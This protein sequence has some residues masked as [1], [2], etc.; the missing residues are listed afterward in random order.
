[1]S[2]SASR[3]NA[4]PCAAVSAKLHSPRQG[5]FGFGDETAH[6]I[7]ATGRISLIAPAVC[8]AVSRVCAGVVFL[9]AAFA[10]ALNRS[11]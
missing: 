5:R 9:L 8:P 10:M 2:G 3:Y 4:N 6:V 1:M 11:R 7:S